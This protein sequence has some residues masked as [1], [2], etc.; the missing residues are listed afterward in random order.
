M[1]TSLQFLL[2]QGARE[3]RNGSGEGSPVAG[4]QEFPRSPN[5]AE[6]EAK[7]AHTSTKLLIWCE[8]SAEPESVMSFLWRETTADVSSG[9]LRGAVPT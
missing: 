2:D 7:L 4:L 9:Q 1:M 8:D 3:I 6:K 5:S